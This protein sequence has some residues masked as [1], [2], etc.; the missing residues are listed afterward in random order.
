M[1]EFLSYSIGRSTPTYGNRNQFEIELKSSIARDDAANESAIR[2]TVHIGTHVDLP[3][4]FHG[5]GQTIEAYDA[6]FWVFD[7]PLLVEVASKNRVIH[8]EL[9][10]KLESYP[11]L[12]YDLL[13][14]KLGTAR[15]RHLRS[16]WEENHGFHPDLAPFLKDQYPSV[17]ILGFDSI[18]VSSFQE[19]ILGRAAHRAFLDPNSTILLLEDMDLSSVDETTRLGRITVA[20]LRI[21]DCDG[22]PCT[23]F[24]EIDV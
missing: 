21:E 10:Q 16:F 19:R 5:S 3:R 6:S 1:I 9:I 24:G 18:S 17:R 15:D 4:H 8:D 20:P 13:L 23:V 2:T 7:K 22:L 12:G 14:V 11:D